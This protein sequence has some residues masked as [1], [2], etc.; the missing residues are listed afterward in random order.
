[1]RA[2]GWLLALAFSAIARAATPGDAYSG[3][4]PVLLQQV[5][6]RFGAATASGKA[7]SELAKLLDEKLPDDLAAWPPV[8]QAY[9][10]A[11]EGLIGKHSPAPWRKYNHAKAGIAQFHGLVEVH[12]DSIE[13]R[14]LRYST[15]S[16]LPDFFGMRAQADADLVALVE[17]FGQ[18]TDP[19]VSPSQRRGYIQWIFDH[20]RPGPDIKTQLEK[21][22]AP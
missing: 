7:S 11:L 1:M 14:M 19:M 12:P 18:G 15:C 3:A 21:L 5:R 6:D 9:R 22:L 13:I 2:T 4:D 20:G 8:F 17:M 16:Q 10:A